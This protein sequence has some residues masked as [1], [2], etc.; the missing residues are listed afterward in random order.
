M[1]L[2]MFYCCKVKGYKLYTNAKKTC[3]TNKKI[4]IFTN[5]WYT[6]IKQKKPF[7]TAFCHTLWRQMTISGF[8][9]FELVLLIHHNHS[10]ECKG[11]Q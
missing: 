6:N 2:K 10:I 4:V 11:C 7:D 9:L 3:K 8:P 1:N 5:I